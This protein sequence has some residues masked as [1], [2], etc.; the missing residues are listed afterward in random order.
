MCTE[1]NALKTNGLFAPILSLPLVPGSLPPFL[2]PLSRSGLLE[3]RKRKKGESGFGCQGLSLFLL[4][5]RGGGRE[6]LSQQCTTVVVV[7]VC[8]LM[9]IRRLPPP[10]PSICRRRSHPF[11]LFFLTY[12]GKRKRGEPERRAKVLHFLSKQNFLPSS[13]LLSAKLP[14]PEAS[15]RN[16]ERRYRRGSVEPRAQKQKPKVGFSY[17]FPPSLPPPAQPLYYTLYASLQPENSPGKQPGKGRGADS[18]SA[19]KLC[20]FWRRIRQS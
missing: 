17:S 15:L 7:V 14:K 10:P 8:L 6:E 11:S 13:S 3:E 1:R 18:F 19:A 2:S 4:Y 9:C 12:R 16:R 5:S 20:F